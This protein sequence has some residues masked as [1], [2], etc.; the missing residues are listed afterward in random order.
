MHWPTPRQ[1]VST[2]AGA[3]MSVADLYGNQTRT[4]HAIDAMFS[5]QLHLLDG[6]EVHEGLRN[7]SQDTLTHW[8]VST[9]SP[10]Q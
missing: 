8:L 1:S 9:Q 3:L 10:T 2:P 4:P 5:P 7:N 6:V